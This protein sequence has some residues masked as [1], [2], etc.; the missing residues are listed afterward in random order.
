MM[1]NQLSATFSR[2]HFIDHANTAEGRRRNDNA[3]KCILLEEYNAA[4]DNSGGGEYLRK[5]S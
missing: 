3:E 5:S 1:L 2:F 4:I